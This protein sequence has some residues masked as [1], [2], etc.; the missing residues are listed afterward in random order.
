MQTPFCLFLSCF[1]SFFCLTLSLSLVQANTSSSP[2]LTLSYFSPHVAPSPPP[3]LHLVLPKG[4]RLLMNQT[5]HR[6][7]KKSLLLMAVKKKKEERKTFLSSPDIYLNSRHIQMSMGIN[8]IYQKN[9]HQL[10][11]NL[12]TPD[13]ISA[14]LTMTT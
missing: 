13:I 9:S 2:H 8:T 7:N 12:S 4:A 3:D 6:L 1:P 10:D 14:T 11:Y 5:Q